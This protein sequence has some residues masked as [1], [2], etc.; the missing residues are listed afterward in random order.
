MK[1]DNDRKEE[2]T[3]AQTENSEESSVPFPNSVM[4]GKTEREQTFLPSDR[5]NTYTAKVKSMA[6]DENMQEALRAVKSNKGAPGIDGITTEEIE[7]IMQKQR[8]T[9]KQQILEGKYIP[10]PVRRVEIPKPNGNGVRQLG[11]PTVID[12]IIQPTEEGTP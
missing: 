5:K 3:E 10:K 6:S 8:P 4:V 1:T 2:Q 7:R 9:I 11:I 12:R